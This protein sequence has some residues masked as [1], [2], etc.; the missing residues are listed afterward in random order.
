MLRWNR[1][2]AMMYAVGLPIVS[3]P[4]VLLEN[5]F[6]HIEACSV[7]ALVLATTLCVISYAV[8]RKSIFGYIVYGKNIRSRN[9]EKSNAKI[10]RF[11][12]VYVCGLQIW[13]AWN[14]LHELAWGVSVV[15][16]LTWGFLGTAIILYAAAWPNK[17]IL[18]VLDMCRSFVP[19]AARLGFAGM[20]TGGAIV[21]G[22]V[23]GVPRDIMMKHVVTGEDQSVPVCDIE[24][25]NAFGWI[26]S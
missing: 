13:C 2:N 1:R 16:T 19:Y 22:M 14:Y 6:G 20:G 25:Y 10:R 26:A 5:V 9:V 21:H 17:I 23:F 3:I 4:V 15:R 24:F 8:A 18:S 11:A 7:S 12:I